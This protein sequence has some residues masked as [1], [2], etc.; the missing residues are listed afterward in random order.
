MRRGS[1]YRSGSR[2]RKG[3]DGGDVLYKVAV[4]TGDVKNA[5][6]DAKVRR[7]A[8]VKCQF[9]RMVGFWLMTDCVTSIRC[10]LMMTI[11][12]WQ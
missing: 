3:K 11:N 9:S 2:K 4:T 10:R 5:G 7:K 1:S 8:Y 12:R 6:T